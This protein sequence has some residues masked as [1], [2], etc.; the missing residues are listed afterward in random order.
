MIIVK[1]LHQRKKSG[2]R[3]NNLRKLMQAG[4]R[5]VYS[6]FRNRTILRSKMC[7]LLMLSNMITVEEQNLPPKMR[8]IK[9]YLERRRLLM[10]S[11]DEVHI[12]ALMA[13]FFYQ[14]LPDQC[15]P[16]HNSLDSRLNCNIYHDLSAAEIGIAWWL[17]KRGSNHRR[18]WY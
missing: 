9:K 12:R 13:V 2:R 14:S 16:I 1:A 4:K 5:F 3:Q 17:E 7:W 8:T 10:N 11:R 18:K 6:D 15:G